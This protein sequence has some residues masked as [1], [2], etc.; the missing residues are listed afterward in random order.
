MNM[1]STL[2]QIPAWTFKADY[3]ETCNCNYGC[4]CNFDGFPS[5]GFCRTLVL[6]HI[7]SGNY[8]DTSLDGIDV[9][10]AIS[11]PKAIHEGNG[12]AQLFISKNNTNNEQRNAIISIFS[13]Q[14]KGEGPFAL[15]AGTI[16]FFLHKE[17]KLLR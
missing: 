14:A 11:W 1:T 8:G 5:N 15:F 4:P 10:S 16:K 9:I 17:V 12:T 13:G 6:F 3:V 2:S 7:R